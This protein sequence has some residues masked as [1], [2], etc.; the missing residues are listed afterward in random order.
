[1]NEIKLTKEKLEELKAELQERI[2]TL[3]QNINDEVR[4]AKDRGDLKENSEYHIARDKQATN[5]SRITEI[6]NILK[7]AEIITTPTGE[8]IEIGSTCKVTDESNTELSWQIV[9]PSEADFMSGKISSESPIG[10]ALLGKKVGDLVK[11]NTKTGTK[12][13]KIISV[14]E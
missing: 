1:M 13:Y 5:E 2:N 4:I 11:I 6:E 7:N 12:K 14:N 9:S 8:S 3:R 10:E